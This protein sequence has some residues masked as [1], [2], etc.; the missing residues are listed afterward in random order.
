MTRQTAFLSYQK[1]SDELI[2]PHWNSRLV[3]GP[4][5][6]ERFQLLLF[7]FSDSLK[8]F[9]V[10]QPT[11]WYLPGGE[12]RAYPW[13]PAVADS[14]AAAVPA[15]AAVGVGTLD[16]HRVPLCTMIN[17]SETEAAAGHG[18]E[19]RHKD[20]ISSLGLINEEDPTVAPTRAANTWSQLQLLQ[21]VRSSLSFASFGFWKRLEGLSTLS[22]GSLLRNTRNRWFPT[23]FSNGRMQSVPEQARKCSSQ[24]N[25]CFWSDGPT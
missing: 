25:V 1:T 10:W 9:W 13:V 18:H 24:D 20:L 6:W 4:N 22:Y 8:C 23:S 11:R 5:T 3:L 17:W 21:L 2:H 12:D 14:W 7:Q 15:A 16:Q 19:M